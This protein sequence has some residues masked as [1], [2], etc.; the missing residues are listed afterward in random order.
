MEF[1]HYNCH[2]GR[3]LAANLVVLRRRYTKTNRLPAL[4]APW[5]VATVGGVR[6]Q[7]V[8]FIARP[9]TQGA[10]VVPDA[11]LCVAAQCGVKSKTLSTQ[12]TFTFMAAAA[13]V[14]R[15]RG[16]GKLHFPS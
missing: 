9:V 14:P 16:R 8:R 5:T 3:H 10:C 2:T 13:A 4:A 6:G 11:A 12:L 7:S 1:S 15:T